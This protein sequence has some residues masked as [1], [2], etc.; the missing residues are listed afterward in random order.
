MAATDRKWRLLATGCL[1][2]ACGFLPA[3]WATYR[4]WKPCSPCPPDGLYT[5]AGHETLGGVMLATGAVL[6]LCA[7]LLPDEAWVW[8]VA[9]FG[10]VLALLG[11]V[12]ATIGLDLEIFDTWEGVRWGV[13]P[14]GALA[15]AA[16]GSLVAPHA[17]RTE[18]VR[19]EAGDTGR[20]QA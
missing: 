19:A 18:A 13:F 6:V 15:F 14:A 5:Q 16:L 20:R 9:V 4:G 17:W 2:G 12:F 7:L 1:V 8:G 3:P 10:A 11:P